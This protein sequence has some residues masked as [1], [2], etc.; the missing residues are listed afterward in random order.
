MYILSV[1]SL[2]TNITG[3]SNIVANGQNQLV[4]SCM[5]GVSYPVSDIRWLNGSTE[6]AS[7]GAPADQPSDYGGV[8][9]TKTLT[10]RPTREGDGNIIA[11]EAW[12]ELNHN[13]P[14]RSFVTLN[15]RCKCLVLRFA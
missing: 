11:C 6:I 7:S 15:L 5:T 9:R 4:L 8:I 3:N 12:N 1:K 2:Y 14:V 13:S 10:L